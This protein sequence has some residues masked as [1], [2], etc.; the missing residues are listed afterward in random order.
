MTKLSI[1]L[2]AIKASTF[3]LALAAVIGISAVSNVYADGANHGTNNVD[4]IHTDKECH[5]HAPKDPND[6]KP[7][8]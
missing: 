4:V 5:T 2:T 3:A 6:I 8:N 1:N 7:A